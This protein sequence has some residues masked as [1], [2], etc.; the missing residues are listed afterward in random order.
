LQLEAA[1]PD[2][3]VMPDPERFAAICEELG[4]ELRGPPCA[5]P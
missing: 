2:Q 3:P 1:T 5:L 4:I